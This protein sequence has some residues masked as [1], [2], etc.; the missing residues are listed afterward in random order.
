MDEQKTRAL[1]LLPLQGEIAAGNLPR[2]LPWAM[3]LLGFQP[4]P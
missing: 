1:M 3:R 2:A 4:A